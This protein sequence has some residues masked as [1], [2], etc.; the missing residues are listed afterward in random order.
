VIINQSLG[1]VF[2]HIPK[3]AG[4]SITKFLSRLNGPLDLELGGTHFGEEITPAYT[5]RFGIGK[6]STL[7]EVA[8]LIGGITWPTQP[9]LFTIVRH[10]IDRFI[11][12][13]DFLR[14]WP[15][16][17]PEVAKKLNR[18]PDI[19]S[20]IESGEYKNVWLGPDNLF[21]PQTRWLRDSEDLESEIN[22]FKLEHINHVFLEIKNRLQALGANPEALDVEL[23]RVNVTP[24]NRSIPS[25]DA[26]EDLRSHYECDLSQLGYFSRI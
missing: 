6:H 21:A 14:K 20:F 13:Y 8:D 25:K 19:S 12:A 4:T 15:G 24:G 1:F 18:F 17:G 5:R 9:F 26:L 10:P 3:A 22:V 11:S 16:A 23:P 7:P 2:I